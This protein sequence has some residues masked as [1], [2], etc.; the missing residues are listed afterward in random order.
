[1]KEVYK[2]LPAKELKEKV[3][4]M[5]IIG[6]N[7]WNEKEDLI[8]MVRSASLAVCVCSCSLIMTG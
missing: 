4:R 8:N 6:P 2:E 1:V 3:A 7:Q 5:S